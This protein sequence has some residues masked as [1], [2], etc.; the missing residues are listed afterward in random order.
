MSTEDMREAEIGAM[1]ILFWERGIEEI[2]S[3]TLAWNAYEH[4]PSPEQVKKAK[5]EAEQ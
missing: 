4:A 1:R 2:E 5:Q 3:Y